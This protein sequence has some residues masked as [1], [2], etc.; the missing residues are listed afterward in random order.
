MFEILF[1]V[2][3]FLC[4][5]GLVYGLMVSLVNRDAAGLRPAH[6][7][8]PERGRTGRPLRAHRAASRAVVGR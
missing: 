2:G 7:A 1:G 4:V 8:R 6:G 5:M 3:Q